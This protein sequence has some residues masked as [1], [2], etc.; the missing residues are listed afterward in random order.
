VRRVGSDRLLR[1]DVVA[2][3]AAAAKEIS[4]VYSSPERESDHVLI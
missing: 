4:C 2:I 3:A 1:I